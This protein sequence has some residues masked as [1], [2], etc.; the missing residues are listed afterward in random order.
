MFLH[1]VNILKKTRNNTLI[2]GSMGLYQ[3]HAA[4]PYR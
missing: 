2:V 3:A 4:P 1:Y